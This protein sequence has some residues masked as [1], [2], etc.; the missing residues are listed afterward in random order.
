MS[1]QESICKPSF[2]PC[3]GPDCGCGVK[4]RASN[5]KKVLLIVVSLAVGGILVFKFLFQAPLSPVAA[6]AAFMASQKQSAGQVGSAADTARF[7]VDSLASLG[8]LNQKA[9]NRDAVMVW[10]PS[11]IGESIPA[12]DAAALQSAWKAIRE[13]GTRLSVY[14]LQANSADHQNMI[15]QMVLPVVL[16]MSKGK[17]MGKVT[18]EITVDKVLQAYVASSGSGGCCPSSGCG[19][20]GAAGSACPPQKY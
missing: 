3:C 11:K 19:P 5:G 1:E 17:G 10:V 18:G 7:T 12:A 14:Q 8:E 2:E 13:K 16:V 6:N 15:G 20:S 4:P 9:L